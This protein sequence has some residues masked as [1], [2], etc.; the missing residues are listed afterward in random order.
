ML[1][2]HLPSTQHS[3]S[4]D[5]EGGG[6]PRRA[7]DWRLR[8]RGKEW[9]L[10]WDRAALSFSGPALTS[11]RATSSRLETRFSAAPALTPTILS[12]REISSSERP[13][14]AWERKCS[15]Q[16]HSRFWEGGKEPSQAPSTSGNKSREPG[17]RLG[18]VY[19]WGCAS[20]NLYRQEVPSPGCWLLCST[21]DTWYEK[22]RPAG[23][24]SHRAQCWADRATSKAEPG[25]WGRGARERQ[26]GA[27]LSLIWL[28]A[29]TQPCGTLCA[30][31]TNRLSL[32]SAAPVLSHR[33]A[34]H[35]LRHTHTHPHTHPHTHTHTHTHTPHTHTLTH[36]HINTPLH[37]PHSPSH[38]VIQAQSPQEHRQETQGH[39][40]SAHTPGTWSVWEQPRVPAE[41]SRWNFLTLGATGTLEAS[42]E[43]GRQWRNSGWPSSVQSKPHCSIKSAATT[44][45]PPT[46]EGPVFTV[47]VASF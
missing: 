37:T 25:G 42:W 20:T 30:S 35:T 12:L 2:Q 11:E 28:Q 31:Q 38:T 13:E 10:R 39:R 29:V 43:Q 7:A 4:R 26:A 33:Q 44:S 32:C 14:R 16:V 46:R 5:K 23:R 27:R 21:M 22:V 41:V 40:G 15:L 34:S 6:F 9:A 36:R 24:A 8:S 45:G 47:S 18:N 3:R 19:T 1:H 17:Q